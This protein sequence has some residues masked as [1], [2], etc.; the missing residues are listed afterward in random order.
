MSDESDY[1]QPGETLDVDRGGRETVVRLNLVQPVDLVQ[2]EVLDAIPLDDAPPPH[3]VWDK[4]NHVATTEEPALILHNQP[5]KL[6]VKLNGGREGFCQAIIGKLTGG[7]RELKFG[8]KLEGVAVGG[9]FEVELETAE[10][11][12]EKVAVNEL[13]LELYFDTGIG[14]AGEQ[15]RV[16]RINKKPAPLRIYTGH[17]APIKNTQFDSPVPHA[18]KIH[19]EH[20][21]RWANGASENIGEGS[22]SIP[23]QVDNQMRHYVHPDDWPGP[24]HEYASV[25]APG[26]RLPRNYEDLPGRVSG[27]K[28]SVSPLYY[29]P[30]EPKEDYEEY[31]PHYQNNFGW[32]LL[33]NTNHTGGRCN[34]QAALICEI[35]GVLGIKAEVYYLQRVGTGKR[36]GRPVR[37]FF[38]CEPGGQFWNF[39][40]IVKVELDD[41]SYHM[42]DGSF[43][44]PPN[45]KHGSEAWAI[46]ERGPFIYSW[47]PWWQYQDNRQRVPEDDIPDTWEGVP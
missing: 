12:T 27:G 18:S 33:D 2:V 14:A 32:K 16:K 28:R 24:E 42:Y 8:R 7:P 10:P 39:H 36:T 4:E 38:N 40:G 37:Q 3:V 6:K 30:L 47:S 9:A 17:K 29:P 11:L 44:W 31:Y 21:C 19:L 5:L 1:T 35:L 45:R 15:G 34:Q 20:A 13:E 23:H 43:S 41:G 22:R 25:Y 46:G 26:S